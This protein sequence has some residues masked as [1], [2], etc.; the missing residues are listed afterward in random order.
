MD[1]KS[2]TDAPLVVGDKQGLKNA[3]RALRAQ[4]RLRRLKKAPRIAPSRLPEA[5]YYNSLKRAVDV[6]RQSVTHAVLPAIDAIVEAAPAEVRNDDGTVNRRDEFDTRL[7]RAIRNARIFYE[8]HVALD[9]PAEKAARATASGHA[10]A[11]KRVVKQVLGVQPELAEP[12][13]RPML[14]S[15]VR[16]NARLVGK[17]GEQF[18]DRLEQRIGDGVR[19]GR[20]AESLRK[21]IAKDFVELEGLSVQ[22]A[23]RRAK[24]IARDQIGSFTGELSRIRQTQLGITR[25]VWRTSKD[26][27]VRDSHEEREGKVFEWGRDIQEQL[28]EQGLKVDDVDGHPGAP[29]NCRCTPEPVLEDLLGPSEEA[30]A[31]KRERTPQVAAPEPES[32]LQTEVTAPAPAIAPPP[33]LPPA[34]PEPEPEIEE[35]RDLGAFKR[36]DIVTRKPLGGGANVTEL[37]TYRD[38]DGR[39]HVGVYK[40]KSGEDGSLRGNVPGGTFYRREEA[41]YLVDQAMA[42]EKIVPPTT[43]REVAGDLGSVQKFVPGAPTYDSVQYTLYGADKKFAK[44]Q[45]VKRMWL[46]DIIVGH[47]DRHEGNVL[48]RK[49]RKTNKPIAIDN[50]LAFPESSGTWFR[51]PEGLGARHITYKLDEARRKM[52]NS[53][54]VEELAAQLK[55]TGISETAIAGTLVRVRAL[56]LDP[57]AISKGAYRPDAGGDNA[58]IGQW[59]DKS[60]DP[61]TASAMV[62]DEEYARLRKLASK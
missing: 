43:I 42:G 22:Q 4:G 27:R 7:E 16:Q 45:S 37:V 59:V 44:Q 5:E 57:D 10:T 53:I 20:R 60:V 40:P 28:E 19:R 35:P 33:P 41:A 39:E 17:V 8:R 48:L 3:V 26:E 51:F 21:E 56:Q 18:Y 47:S 34:E 15:F 49:E 6:L 24:G 13:L 62:G 29:F 52:I 14:D 38:A 50:G 32:E 36:G 30:P 54:D 12:W 2:F 1:L 9:R 31:P 23:L 58:H 46:F 55:T 25:Y 61:R 11:E